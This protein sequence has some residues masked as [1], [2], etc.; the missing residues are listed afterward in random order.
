MSNTETDEQDFKPFFDLI[1]GV[2][3][4]L[5]I[6]ISAQ[7]FFAQS[8][9]DD[10]KDSKQIELERRKQIAAF[11]GDVAAKLKDNGFDPQIDVEH[12]MVTLPME[13]LRSRSTSN[14]PRFDEAKI[15]A[16]TR[17]L[18][19]PLSCAS[20][21]VPTATTCPNWNLIHLGEA[22]VEAGV[23]NAPSESGL[24]RER[25]AQLEAAVLAAAVFSKSPDLLGLTGS[26][27]GPLV[28]IIGGSAPPAADNLQIN[29]AFEK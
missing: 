6:L 5:L 24:S 9:N 19:S 20:G 11:M 12:K 26:G 22:V 7:M 8:P 13:P 10:V 21:K 2:L 23:S 15:V 16:L 14:M 1:V 3:F 25:Y 17:S 4:I 18:L 29:F 27:G 28:R